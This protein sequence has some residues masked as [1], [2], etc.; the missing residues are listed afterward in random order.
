V[1]VHLTAR[2]R[3]LEP[4]LAAAARAINARATEGLTPDEAEHLMGIVMRIIANLGG[5]DQQTDIGAPR[6]RG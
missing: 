5:R 1:R 6:E 2:G 4:T 3:A